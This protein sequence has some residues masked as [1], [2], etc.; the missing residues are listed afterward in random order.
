M[1]CSGFVFHERN[2]KCVVGERDRK[3]ATIGWFVS[4]GSPKTAHGERSQHEVIHNHV[5]E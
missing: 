3:V 2:G 1:Q 5:L 4:T